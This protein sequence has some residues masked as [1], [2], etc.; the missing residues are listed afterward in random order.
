MKYLTAID[1]N[2][3]EL[4]NAKVQN[5][6]TDPA[7]LVSGNAGRIWYNTTDNHAKVWNGTAVDY[8]SNL[9]ETISVDATLTATPSGKNVALAVQVASANTASKIVTR[10]SSG[11]FSAGTIT[12]SLTGTASNASALGTQTLSQ[13]RDF[14]QTTGTRD[15]TSISDFDTQVRS[16][17]LDQMAAPISSLSFNS[18]K[19]VNVLDPTGPQDVASKNYVDSVASGLDA[20][21]S[22]RV[23]T[24]AALAANTYANGT[25]GV[26]ATLT[27][28]S[29]GVIAAIDGQN[30]GAAV[31]QTITNVTNSTT[32][33]TAT[34][35][36]TAGLAIG[37]TVTIAGITGFTTNN[38]N[39]TFVVNTIPSG[40][41]FTYIVASAPTGSYTSGGTAVANADRVL[42]KNEATAANNGIYVVTQIGTAGTPYILTRATDANTN[43]TITPGLFTFIEQGSTNGA[44]GWVLSTSGA[45]T[46]GTTS[47]NFSQFSS[48]TAYSAGN[49]LQLSTGAFSVVGTANRISVSGSGV[50]ISSSYVGQTSITTLGTVTT[51][52]WTGTAIAVANGGTGAT[53]AASARTNLGA[54]GKAA[55]NIPSGASYAFAH[56]LGTTD[57]DVVVKDTSSLAIVQADYVVTD[58]NTVTL[59][60]SSSVSANAYRVTVIG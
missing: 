26:G 41:T 44:Q 60:F 36:S 58:S 6:G 22:V 18:Q 28:N 51:G 31:S 32:T 43:T 35:A 25:A 34:V 46:V 49:G 37:Q 57:V 59:T 2:N 19:G 15:H 14:S 1:L 50:D 17:R 39:G 47:L 5:L 42:V 38:P 9:L 7:G 40:T 20:K 4:Q 29:N 12:A 10:D 54:V 27:A 56:N 16:S 53:S 11:N 33:V 3:N 8:L 55:I 30:V 52:T 48:S 45:I 23:A 24:T 13:V 21:A